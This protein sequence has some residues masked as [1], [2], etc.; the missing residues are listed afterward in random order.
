MGGR[1][2]HT[3]PPP[4]PR[5]DRLRTAILTTSPTAG[6]ERS[7]R[8]A[9][10]DSEHVLQL[11]KIRF[12]LPQNRKQRPHSS[13]AVQPLGGV[14]PGGGTGYGCP[15]TLRRI[16]PIAYIWRGTLPCPPDQTSHDRPAT[17]GE[18]TELSPQGSPSPE[19]GLP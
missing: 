5:G 15:N 2:L 12:P 10:R 1:P 16:Y 17:N 13:L 18:R 6:M 19:C 14:S 3:D 11:C 7:A 9:S 8:C 4:R